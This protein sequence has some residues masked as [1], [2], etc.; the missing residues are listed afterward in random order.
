M[1]LRSVTLGVNWR[2]KDKIQIENFIRVFFEKSAALFAKEHMEVRTSR[3]TL[4]PFVIKDSIDNENVNSVVGWISNFCENSGIRWFC[5]PF[6]TFNQDMREINTVAIEI[7][8]RYKNAFI[9]FIVAADGR[10]NRHAIL[11]ASKF[12][13][14][15]SKLS[16]NGYDNFRVGAS[17]NCEANGPFFP[18]TYHSGRDGFSIALELVPLFIDA[19][20]KSKGDRIEVMRSRLLE[21]ISPVLKQVDEIGSKIEELTNMVY[22]G[23]DTSLAPYPD[24]DDNS[25][26]RIVELLGVDG[27]GSCGTVFLTSYLTDV[28]Q[29]LLVTS[30]I[31]PVGFNGVMYSLLEDTRLGINNSSKEFSID[32]LL[33]FSAVCG[34]GV[35]MVPVPGDIFEEEIASVMIDLAG[36]STVLK[37]PLGV[38][39]LPIPAKH[40]YEFTE[41]SY[42]FLHNTR[43]QKAKNRA[44][45]NDFIDIKAPF[46]YLQK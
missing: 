33:A 2:N 19:I 17:F 35:D 20:E 14:S 29:E 7:A 3:L 10:L 45:F 1:K 13:K 30:G 24:S 39:I 27:F 21:K 5:V 8:K 37:K 15:V 40:A 23:T 31:R 43:I 32:S 36:I 42:D 44:C 38:R 4:P 25:V 28:I 11:Y 46:S 16:N 34:C 18:F 12:I 26:A 22:Y 41:F 9:N 6:T